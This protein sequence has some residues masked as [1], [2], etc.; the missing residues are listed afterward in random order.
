MQFSRF[1]IAMIFGAA[2]SFAM[3]AQISL[4]ED[5]GKEDKKDALALPINEFKKVVFH[6]FKTLKDLDKRITAL[7]QVISGLIP[8][9]HKKEDNK[10]PFKFLLG[11]Y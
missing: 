1:L 6:P 11:Q 4:A 10:N 2:L 7:L 9:A 5:A 3:I 8:G